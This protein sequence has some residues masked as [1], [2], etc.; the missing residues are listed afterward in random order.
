MR[1]KREH[2]INVRLTSK[3][4]A[5]V[6]ALSDSLGGLS[7]SDTVRQCIGDRFRKAFP[8]YVRKGESAG[9]GTPKDELTQE[10]IVEMLGGRVMMYEGVKHGEFKQGAM[11]SRIILSMIGFGDYT[12]EKLKQKYGVR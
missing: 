12:L 7:D 9:A 4:K 1:I 5:M 11:V 6:D 8:H 10:Q 3:E 2:S